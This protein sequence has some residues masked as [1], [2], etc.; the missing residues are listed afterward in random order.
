MKGKDFIQK[1]KH[2]EY[3]YFA[4]NDVSAHFCQRC[5]M[6]HFHQINNNSFEFRNV[7]F[8][9]NSF[10]RIAKVRKQMNKPTRIAQ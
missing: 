2:S 10:Y 7:S 5:K 9:L 1:K 6:K 4:R 8:K 3:L